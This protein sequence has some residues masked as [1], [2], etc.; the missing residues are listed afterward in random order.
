MKADIISC[1][2]ICKCMTKSVADSYT[3]RAT[4][5]LTVCEVG[6]SGERSVTTLEN[7]PTSSL[8]NHLSSSP[9][10]IFLRD[11]GIGQIFQVVTDPLLAFFTHYY[12]L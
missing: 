11:Y 4:C 8:R 7:T 1:Y 5:R 12:R 3:N 2:C 10:G 9:M 6:V